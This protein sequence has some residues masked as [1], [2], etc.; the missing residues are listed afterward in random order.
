MGVLAAFGLVLNLVGGWICRMTVD[1]N[2][3]NT[4]KPWDAGTDYYWENPDLSFYGLRNPIARNNRILF[5][6]G[7]YDEVLVCWVN[8]QIIGGINKYTNRKKHMNYDEA[9]HLWG[10]LTNRDE[11][12]IPDN[13]VPPRMV[14]PSHSNSGWGN[15]PEYSTRMKTKTNYAL[16]E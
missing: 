3:R 16:E 8:T 5:F 15:P 1:T 4:G 13:S 10:C 9:R 14:E 6:P 12:Y 7:S 11:M 2:N